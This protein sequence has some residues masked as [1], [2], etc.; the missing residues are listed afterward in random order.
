MYDQEVLANVLPNYR[1]QTK[2]GRE[3]SHLPLHYSARTKEFQI[4]KYGNGIKFIP[5]R[6]FPVES[7]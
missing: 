1:N 2:P 5:W 3:E 7:K 4:H 6:K